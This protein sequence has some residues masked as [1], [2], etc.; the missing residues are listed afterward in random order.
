DSGERLQRDDVL[1]IELER[2]FEFGVGIPEPSVREIGSTEHDAIADAAS[3]ACAALFA[4]ADRLFR[5]PALQKP[6][7]ERKVERRGRIPHDDLLQ[8]PVRLLACFVPHGFTP[9]RTRL[10]TTRRRVVSDGSSKTLDFP[11]RGHNTTRKC[12]RPRF[13]SLPSARQ[14]LGLG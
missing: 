13:L 3:G 11:S 4:E 14:K 6:L 7:G 9:C 1:A 10:R 8:G 5:A 2:G 12:F